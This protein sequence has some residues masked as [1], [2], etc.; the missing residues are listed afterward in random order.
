MGSAGELSPGKDS[1]TRSG[2]AVCEVAALYK[3]RFGKVQGVRMVG[4]CSP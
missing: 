3:V 1:T 2:Q 4:A